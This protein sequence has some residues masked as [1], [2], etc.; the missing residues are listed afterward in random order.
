MTA[1][2]GAII[3]VM[4]L[5]VL[6]YFSGS[7][8]LAPII[9]VLHQE[10]LIP[11]SEETWRLNA[12]LL[13]T[14]PGY[15]GLALTFLWGVMGDK[16]G[17]RKLILILG[18]IMGASLLAVSTATNYYELLGYLTLFGVAMLG[19]GPVIYAFIADVV[20]S[21]GRGKGYAAY[22]ASSV[23]GM[24]LGLLLAGILFYWRTAYLIVGAPVLVFAVVLYAVS[25]GVT[26]GYSEEARVGSYSL[27][28]AIKEALTPSVLLIMI[29]IVTW[30]I[31]WGML[32]LF[33]VEYLETRWGIDKLHATL[34]IMVATISI[35]VGHI[36]GGALSD[37]LAKTQ[38]PIGRVKVS[39]FG[40]II[41]YAAMVA[42]LTYPYPYGDMSLTALLPPSVLAA[43]GMMFTTFAYPNISTVISDCVRP[44]HRGT[45]FSIYNILNNLGWATGPALYG[46][47]IAYLMT[48]GVARETAMM[49]SATL[50][51]S[52]WII[53]LV[54]WVLLGKFY[55]K[56]IKKVKE[57]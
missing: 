16:L 25:K 47:L 45:V 17:R 24:V 21:E 36:I 40:I 15:I 43:A 53:S 30:T 41:G 9:D 33:S 32:A 7:Y 34:V 35:A 14:V 20:P 54:I 11:G 37:K 4:A 13:K 12:G 5:M 1:R 50:I 19:I 28:A 2:P 18:L 31:P 51:V 8:M 22:Y 42:M 56:D 3:I 57:I 39:I 23:L 27:S 6:F 38:G 29:Q 26:I 52:L 10:G 55:P 49:Y 46:G 44:E 48:S